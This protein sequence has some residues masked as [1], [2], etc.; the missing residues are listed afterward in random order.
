MADKL[1]L[2]RVNIQS[3]VGPFTARELREAYKRMDFGLQD[4]VC[5]SNRRWVAFDDLPRIKRHY[6][7]LLNLVRKEMLS[8]WGVTEHTRIING[9]GNRSHRKKGISSSIA[10]ILGL[11]LVVG[12][13]WFAV[14]NKEM[15][16]RIMDGGDPSSSKATEWIKQGKVSRVRAYVNKYQKDLIRK[17][18]AREWLPVFRALAFAQGAQ[19]SWPGINSRQLRGR[20][21]GF[22]PK[23]CSE[24]YWKS[25]WKSSASR[26][27]AYLAGRQLPGEDWAKI[28]LWDPAWI[29]RRSPQD[30]WIQPGSYYEGCLK[31]ALKAMPEEGADPNLTNIR[32]RLTFQISMVSDKA[33]PE[34]ITM[35]GS[36][37]A[38]SCL[39]STVKLEEFK[40]CLDNPDLDREWQNLLKRRLK[41]NI[42]R[43]L[44][45]GN[46]LQKSGGLTRFREVVDSLTYLDPATGFEYGPEMRYFQEILQTA[47]NTAR[48]RNNL[49]IRYPSVRFSD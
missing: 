42:I 27:E 18:S 23:D 7:E 25:Q 1:Y 10:G 6:P 9:N 41:L 22:A 16:S 24:S 45:T 31:M 39:E 4:E 32:S 46:R 35:S 49:L 19:G 47:G 38:L 29:K 14:K 17:K 43:V 12:L 30:G 48:A 40:D 37:W 11:G 34:N 28:L 13:G 5:A 8:G 3:F 20:E 21:A 44:I 33:I 36:L 15:F 26:Q 2:V